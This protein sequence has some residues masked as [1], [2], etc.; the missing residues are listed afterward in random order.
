M[1]MPRPSPI[2][3]ISISTGILALTTAC[4]KANSTS[5]NSS[6]RSAYSPVLSGPN[7]MLVTLGGTTLCGVKGYDNEPCTSITLCAPGTSNCQTI[8]DILVDT[9]S[10]GLR[11]FSS[12][13]TVELTPVIDAAS[14]KPLAQCAQF[15]RDARIAMPRTRRPDHRIN[16]A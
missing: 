9:G 4:G 2:I 16:A 5:A 6:D 14:N 10:V 1:I 15:G 7:V 3:L 11:I 8:T 13:I 12:V